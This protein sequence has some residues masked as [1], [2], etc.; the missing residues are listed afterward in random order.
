MSNSFKK[1]FI[2]SI[3]YSISI[4][5]VW[6]FGILYSYSL[7]PS[8]SDGRLYIFA[9]WAA[10]IKLS[11]CNKLGFDVFNKNECTREILDNGN[12]IL[13]IPF[14]KPFTKFY[15][16]ILP[17]IIDFI[18]IF[19]LVRSIN[20]KKILDYLLLL[21]ILIS[22]PVL[23]VL[24]RGNLDIL[25]F[26]GILLIVYFNKSFINF[27]TILILS[28]IKYYP[29]TLI[30]NFFIGKEYNFKKNI[31]ALFIFILCFTFA[32][33]FLGENFELLIRKLKVFSITWGNQFSVKAL[34]IIAK[35]HLK[36]ESIYIIISSYLFFFILTTIHLIK[37]KKINFLNHLKLENH[38]ERLFI[39]GANLTITL[40]IFLA[41][42]H[43]KEIFLILLLPLLIR[44]KNSD[45]NIFK[46][47]FYFTIGRLIFF[48]FCNYFILFKKILLL[49]YIKALIDLFYMS[50]LT[51]MI[52]LINL[53]IFKII[54][55][56][57]ITKS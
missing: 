27:I 3:I 29:L 5:Y 17:L 40:F 21:L 49:L 4:Y 44:L 43:Y 56:K 31:F 33:Y 50:F 34:S 8:V 1:N 19:Y 26:L 24:E 6:K 7:R 25:I 12:I 16:Y 38:D 14:F 11:I 10:M 22:P 57:Q 55:F 48:I 9:D 47:F 42:I 46:Y 41:N 13:L 18:F 2:I 51:A 37:F 39:I 30:I 35:N 15:F 32:A 28:L 52:I 20:P 54:P 53:A 45:I 23:L 36:N